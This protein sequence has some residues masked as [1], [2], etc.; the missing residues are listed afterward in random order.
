MKDLFLVITCPKLQS[1]LVL[2]GCL[3]S[4]SESCATVGRGSG[5]WLG[6]FEDST[7]TPLVCFMSLSKRSLFIADCD[8]DTPTSGLTASLAV[9]QGRGTSWMEFASPTIADKVFSAN[10]KHVVLLVFLPTTIR[11]ERPKIF[12]KQWTIMSI[13]CC[14][15]FDHGHV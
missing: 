4:E 2:N 9:A 8:T 3:N 12:Y 14:C 13:F 15:V 5:D 6:N 11:M 1:L 10:S 7:F